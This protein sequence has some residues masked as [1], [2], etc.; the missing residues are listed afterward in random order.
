MDYN[1]LLNRRA[2]SLKPSG[3]RKYFDIV[4]TMDE[5]ISL[6]VGEPDFHT[7]WHIR[8]AGIESLE[9]GRTRY[10]SNWG[11]AELRRQISG[12]LSRRFFLDYS[13]DNEIMVTVGGSEA[14]D[15]SLRA[16]VSPDDEVMIPEPSFVCYAPLVTLCSGTPVI[17][18]TDSSNGF[19]L[20]AEELKRNITPKTK[21]LILPYPNNPT[22]AVMTRED[23]ETIADVLKDTDIFILSDEIYA[24]LT[25]SG[26]HV[27]I[28][29]LPGM[30]ERTIVA[31]GFSKAYSMTGW[32]MGY[33]CG[34]SEVIKQMVKIHQFAIMSAPTTS[35]YASIE[36]IKNGDGDIEKMREE[37]DMRRKL[38]V[39]GFNDIGLTCFEPLGAFYAF[40]SIEKTGLSSDRFCEEL[41][42]KKHVAVI[43]GT[44]FGECG[45]GHFRASYC[46][47][48][49][50]IKT[51]L[52]R[53]HEFLNELGL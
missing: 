42:Y 11:L 34:P 13:P 10:T 47:S 23:L 49:A 29:S 31:N 35:Q 41:L 18:K 50:H 37:Y 4:E 40:P 39:K 1:K 27:S 16:I 38:I 44:A 48:I 53:I 7:P 32:R 28:A 21:A 43:P 22:G 15:V 25:Y 9:N 6:G 26:H 2:V 46:Y 24:E 33:A 36:A 51:A 52:E 14:I 12:Y 20:T 5:V 45:Q 8:R 19:K 3:I 30:R 17:L